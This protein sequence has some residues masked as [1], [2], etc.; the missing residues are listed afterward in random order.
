MRPAAR[1]LLRRSGGGSINEGID[2]KD[3]G[4][5][6]TPDVRERTPDEGLASL[7]LTI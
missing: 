3:E 7:H 1:N 5:G 2:G 6:Q 4:W